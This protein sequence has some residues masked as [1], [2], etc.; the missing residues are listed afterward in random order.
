MPRS[1]LVGNGEVVQR[2]TTSFTHG[3]SHTRSFHRKEYLHTVPLHIRVL[4]AGP[5]HM[6]G[7]FHIGGAMHTGILH[8]GPLHTDLCT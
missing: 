4:H 1:P 8:M 5:L 6:G 7:T 2:L 3:T